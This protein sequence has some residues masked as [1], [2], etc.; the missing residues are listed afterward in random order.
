[1]RNSLNG[2]TCAAFVSL[3]LLSACSRPDSAAAPDTTFDSTGAEV[4]DNPK[5]VASYRARLISQ[6]AGSYRGQCG[7]SAGEITVS[8]AGVVS[9][10]GFKHDLNGANVSLSLSR[11]LAQ[12]L[13]AGIEFRTGSAEPQWAFALVSGPGELASV[14]DAASTVKCEQV[15]QV[16]SLRAKPLYPQVAAFFTASPARLEC[17]GSG[18]KVLETGLQ[19]IMPGADGVIV[20]KARFAFDKGIK[21]E[22]VAF[23]PDQ[24]TL[25]YS[26][27]YDDDATLALRVDGA[28]KLSDVM[29][30]STNGGGMICSAP[31]S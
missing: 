16:T 2:S 19:P 15:A 14:T 10:K 5:L 13:P 31:R 29:W 4:A 7:D 8:P 26:V 18:E 24:R 25:T 3:A 9:V 30:T 21:T 6:V 1:M 12:G 22:V 23:E 11:T 20:G 17:A 28:G 27:A